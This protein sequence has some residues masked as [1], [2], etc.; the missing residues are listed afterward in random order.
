[1]DRLRLA[2]SNSDAAIEFGDVC[3]DYF[4]VAVTARDHSG[5]IRVFAYTDGL[6]IARLFSE[7]AQEWKGWNTA[8]VWKSIEGELRL[9]LRSDR[10][11][12]ITLGVRL[13]S[14]PAGVD[15][16]QLDAEIGLE[17]GQIERIARDAERLWNRHGHDGKR[18]E[19]G[20]RG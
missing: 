15:R 4:Q 6:A 18:R 12:H 9:E 7:A 11:G 13:R 16:W 19:P 8:K 5:S 2:S 3:E 10:L 20:E 17:A 1:M 14:E